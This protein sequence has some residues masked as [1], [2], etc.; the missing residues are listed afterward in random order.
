MKNG[1][2]GEV[3]AP[4]D[5]ELEE[6]NKYTR[7]KFSADEVYA[8]S[9]VL[10]DNDV[11]RDFE[12][13]TDEAL[14]KMAELFVGKTGIFDHSHKS[15]NQCARIFSCRLEEVDGKK[16]RL[17][18]QYKRLFAR[19]Y[20][21]N[22]EKSKELILEIDAGIK[23]EVSV[24]CSMARSVCSIC[25]EPMG[26]CSHRKGRH[27][28]TAGA[29]KL[30]FFELSEPT[31]AYEWSFVAVPAQVSAGVVKAYSSSKTYGEVEIGNFTK[32]FQD[33]EV[34]LNAEEIES[35]SKY[36]E[37]LKS[38]A[39]SAGE[40]IAKRKSD[41]ISVYLPDANEAAI[42]TFCKAL[43]LLDTADLFK[44]YNEGCRMSDK[45]VPQLLP[46]VKNNNSKQ[47]NS[48]FIV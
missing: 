6:I 28:R 11:D 44:L 25:G 17:G 30:C 46:N 43:D 16:N 20:M 37:Q 39:Q 19:A 47:K 10:C 8:F 5:L 24:G 26:V 36:I 40:F 34:V 9:V 1:I 41:I 33:G 31:D 18:Q 2:I 23:K 38:T 48:L 27:Y 22:S 14:E 45:C 3:A 7:R 12:R 29:K 32:Q 42:N 21:P 13:F 35:L 15:Q 4:S